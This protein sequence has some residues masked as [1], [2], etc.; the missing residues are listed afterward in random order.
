M[1]TT[2]PDLEGLLE[3]IGIELGDS[4]PKEV[5]GY[6]PGHKQNLGRKDRHPTSWSVRRSTGA[7]WCFS[8]MYGGSLPDLIEEMTG[9]NYW[10]A[11]GL[12]R[13][14][15]IDLADMSDLA[16]HYV[17]RRN[18]PDVVLMDERTLRQFTEPPRK[19]LAKRDISAA[20]ARHFGILWDAEEQCWITPIRLIG[21]ALIGWQAKGGRYFNNYPKGVPKSTTLFGGHVFPEGGTAILMESPLDA[22]RVYTAGFEGGV[23]SYGVYVSD[24][25][26]RLLT[27]VTDEVILALDNDEQGQWLTWWL[28]HGE[29]Q[30]TKRKGIKWG[31]KLDLYVY[32]YKGSAKD[33]GEQSDRAIEHG[34]DNRIPAL[35]W[36]PTLIEV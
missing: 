32:D 27:Q 16:D 11:L 26:M 14:F 6:C 25:Q 1:T 8:C 23:S 7:H 5:Y 21:G 33:P 30:G 9:A 35:D 3:Y 34:I 31:T 18:A 19:A 20:A 29:R 10:N 17:D 36:E 24:D 22:A 13:K 15:G 28:I 2:E 12:C 4:T